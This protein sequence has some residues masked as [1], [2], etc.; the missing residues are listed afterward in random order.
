M[1]HRYLDT[2]WVNLLLLKS[3]VISVLFISSCSTEE[4]TP[5][6]STLCNI[7]EIS[8]ES[9]QSAMLITV[10]TKE[11]WSIEHLSNWIDFTA[12]TGRGKT[13]LLVGATKNDGFGRIDSFLIK[14]AKQTHK[15]YIEQKGAAIVHL[16]ILSHTLVFVKVEGG[17]FKIGNYQNPHEHDVSL[18]EYYIGQ[19]EVTNAFWEAIV[20]SLPY[21]NENKNY[22]YTMD[23]DN[24]DFPVT[25]VSWNDI[26][27]TFLPLL[28]TKTSHTF[29]LPTE[30]EWEFAALGG[31]KSKGYTFS[32]SNI[33]DVVGWDASNANDT[34]QAVAQ[35]EPNEI[36]LYDMSG[37]AAE[38]CSDWY[39]DW[40]NTTEDTTNPTG[41]VSGT[42]KVIR[43]GSIASEAGILG[44]HPCHAK[45]RSYA[46]PS[47]FQGAWGDTGHPDEPVI[48]KCNEIGFRLV[49]VR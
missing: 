24:P 34:K 35:L 36:N 3:V 42:Y 17:T 14:T 40:Y 30:A 10:N 8:F 1:L 6:P 29:R 21:S 49:L 9:E 48:Y 38:W 2:Y 16:D 28:H 25:A 31:N 39:S 27:T 7:S 15:I 37:N 20:G 43:G 22:P 12:T 32:G 18:T 11:S 26:H 46:H 33:L 5:K 13:S 45:Q 41:P 47:G 19:T 23:D 44:F 4:P